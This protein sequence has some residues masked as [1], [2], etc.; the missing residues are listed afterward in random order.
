MKYYYFY[1]FLNNKMETTPEIA[2]LIVIIIAVIFI[3]IVKTSCT[4]KLTGFGVT[5]GL[6]LNNRLAYCQPGNEKEGGA[7]AGGCF[8][9]HRVIF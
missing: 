1:Y 3:V 4:E 2:L 6:A 7:W 8:L 5:T 9:P